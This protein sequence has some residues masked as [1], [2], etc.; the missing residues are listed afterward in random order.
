M[1]S[2]IIRR[3]AGAILVIF[4]VTVISYAILYLA[5]GDPTDLMISPH[6]LPQ[7]RARI[8]ANL[9]LDKPVYVQYFI[10]LKNL[11][12]HG[13]LGYSLVNGRPVLKSILE[14]LPATLLLMG[15]AYLISFLIAVPLGVIAAVKQYSFYDYLLTFLSFIGLSAPSFWL[16]LMAIYFFALKL[17]WFPTTG[18]TSYHTQGLWQSFL[19]VGWHLVLPA[20]V[21]AVRNL[22]GWTRYIRAS[23]LDVINE[24]YIRTA[25]AKG[26]RP[27]TVIFKHALRNALLPVITLAGL[28]LPEITSGAFIIEYI[29]GWPGMGR[30]GMEAVFHRDYTILMGD[31]LLASVMVIL[32]NLIADILYTLADP[33]IRYEFKGK[34]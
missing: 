28:S 7:D 5:P 1:R 4:L 30:L 18:I 12:L 33:R 15:T 31:I 2:Y 17:G 22:A 13:D 11:V 26:L 29:F 10:W 9:G 21:L 34:K 24:D 27:K 6:M 8:K 32:G 14:R 23:M 20:L 25:Y 19:D 16:A 3:L